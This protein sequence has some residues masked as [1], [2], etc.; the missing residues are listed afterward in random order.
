MHRFMFRPLRVSAVMAAAVMVI[1]GCSDDDDSGDSAPP[2]SSAPSSSAPAPSPS[3][4][5]ASPPGTGVAL[6][7][8]LP[9]FPDALTDGDGRA[10][11]TF[12][13]DDNG[14]STCEGQCAV[15]WPPVLTTGPPT[16]AGDPSVANQLGTQ[17]RGDGTMQATYGGWPLYYFFQDTEP[18]QSSGAGL[19]AFGGQFL[20]IQKNTDRVGG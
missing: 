1:A 2:S 15:N 4:P 16:V 20:L 3:E 6:K 8:G 18:G 19:S 13:T 14:N 12:T 17:P 10:V 5:A 7:F 9:D 11:Y